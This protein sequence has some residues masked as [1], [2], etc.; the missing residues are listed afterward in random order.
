MSHGLLRIVLPVLIALP[1]AAASQQPAV[2]AF[3]PA[4]VDTTC[5]PCENFDK[6]ATEGWKKRTPIPAAFAS[7]SSFDE[8]TLRNFD[9]VRDIA[10]SAAQDVATTDP[11]RRKLGLFYSTCMDSVTVESR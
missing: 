11:E 4:D 9:V 7:W 3:N 2:P 6:F 1:A 5:K 8:L 10:E